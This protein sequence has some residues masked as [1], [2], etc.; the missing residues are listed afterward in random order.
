MLNM[1]RHPIQS[2]RRTPRPRILWIIPIGLAVAVSIA[3]AFFGPLQEATGQPPTERRS[4]LALPIGLLAAP[5]PRAAA[6]TARPSA[7]TT[8]TSAPPSLPPTLPDDPQLAPLSPRHLRLALAEADPGA[9]PRTADW[10]IDSV[11]DPAYAE[12][13]QPRSIT[14]RASASALVPQGWPFPAITAHELLLEL[15]SKLVAGRSYRLGQVSSGQTWTLRHDVDRVHTPS[16]HLNTVGYRPGAT[17]AP[18]HYAYASA[19]LA[20]LSPLELADSERD[21]AVVDALSGTVVRRVL[22]SLSLAH[23]E[24]IEEAYDSSTLGAYAAA[25]LLKTSG[26]ARF[27]AALVAHA[28]LVDDPDASLPPWD[29]GGLMPALWA[30][31]TA[32]GAS[33]ARREHGARAFRSRVETLLVWNSRSGHRWTKHPYA[34]VGYGTLTTPAQAAWVLRARHLPRPEPGTDAEDL[35]ALGAHALDYQ[36][37]AN[38]SGRSWVTGLG[39]TAVRQPLHNPSMGDGIAEPVPGIP[40]Y[41]PSHEIE[42]SGLLGSALGAFRPPAGQW[43]PAERFVDVGYV[44]IYNEFT[45]A[46]S[47][48][49]TIFVMGYLAGVGR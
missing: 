13:R 49:P 7:G 48:A 20:G 21:V 26:E 37:G 18:G 35:L 31:A 34:P 19:W 36:L 47:M 14:A 9:S 45:V 10:W 46:E 4:R 24:A 28:P 23:D 33:E 2:S 41:G 42:S 43:P 39:E 29:P 38:P 17:A 40:V 22:L 27:E 32:E 30:L 16:L 8:P 1:P 6:P 44:P 11:D 15:P 25:E 5:I 12:A 3:L